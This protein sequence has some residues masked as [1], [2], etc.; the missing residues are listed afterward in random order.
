MIAITGKT[1]FKYAGMPQFKARLETLFMSG[2]QFI[3]F[4]MALV[5]S[6][7]NLLPPNHPYTQGQNIGKFGIRHVIAEAANNIILKKENTDQIVLFVVL[8]VGLVLI[9]MQ[10]ALLAMAIFMQP[11]FASMPT[12]FAGFFI[13][14]NPE[15]DIAHIMMDLIFGVGDNGNNLF[16]SCIA[17]EITCTETLP[18]PGS[19]TRAVMASTVPAVIGSPATTA[20]IFRGY[21]FPFPI[22]TGM[23][24]MFQ[25]YNTGLL[26]VGA[27][28]TSYFIF[29]IIAETAQTGTAFGKRFNKVWAPLRIVFAFGMLV[30]VGLGFNG[31]QYSVL[32]AA[33]FGSAFAT[34]GWLLFNSSIT[35]GYF[36]D[37][38]E[39]I[40][41]PNIPEITSLL[42]FFYVAKT[43]EKLEEVSAKAPLPGS[44][45]NRDLLIQMYL[46]KGAPNG[47]GQVYHL[48]NQ[49]TTYQQVVDFVENTSTVKIRFGTQNIDLYS[50][51][52]GT[53]NPLC[54][55]VIL[56]LQD[57]RN[58]SASGLLAPE[59]G[60]K[61]MQEFYWQLLKSA[62]FDVFT[63][64]HVISFEN[65]VDAIDILP[66]TNFPEN[67]VR[68][69][70]EWERDTNSPLPDANYARNVKNAFEEKIKEVILEGGVLEE[71]ANSDRFIVNNL[72]TEKGWAG[73]AIWYNR[74]AEMN[75]MVTTAILNVP[76]V[77]KYPDIMEHILSKKKLTDNNSSFETRFLPILNDGD[78]VQFPERRH[79]Q[80]ANALWFAFNH[81]QV[82]GV[83]SS[84][85]TPTG[86]AMIDSI[87][88]IFGT[89]GLYNIRRNP[90]THPLAQI[91]GVGRSL[92]ESSIRNLA[93]SVTGGA[94]GKLLGFIDDS[95]QQISG[96]G[97]TFLV[98]VSMVALTAGF[99]LFYIVPFLPFI[100]FFFAL[101]GWVK[102]I[103]EA[104]VGAPLWALAHIRIDQ[105][106]LPGQAGV[107][108][109]F[110]IFEIFI[111]P[112][113]IIFG[114]L[115]SISIF[116]AL[117][118][119]LH[120]IFDL[121]IE[122]VGGFDNRF[123]NQTSF[124]S[125]ENKVITN[126][127]PS[128]SISQAR[129]AIDE[130]FFTIIYTIIIYLMAMSSFKLIDLIPNNILRWMGQSIATFNDQR[131][132]AAQGLV[133]K[134][135]IGA[136]QTSSALGGGLKKFVG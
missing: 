110:L 37:A 96:I 78:P 64:E 129:G 97:A 62:W 108:G 27:M 24:Q 19:G 57:P 105:N 6:A 20:S 88:A 76:H 80:M 99:V 84:H 93:L 106:G 23:H 51:Y 102:G 28:I 85:A 74:I 134:A 70:T 44:I 122:N 87:N 136:Q 36:G 54:G 117:V 83:T 3:A 72:I 55:E 2:F 73:A 91:V 40:S 77:S 66:N 107:A 7:V 43:C 133:G 35:D 8:L 26:V 22:H 12:N 109:Y 63:S 112:I 31:S 103:F 125:L 123:A 120:Q 100:Y 49:G 59:E 113:L 92:V 131:E 75:G 81:W 39:L 42:Q 33:K 5:Y 128:V 79:A 15:T 21:G 58:P 34:N 135:T 114:M 132:D 38:K 65:S 118:G 1:I 90:N 13:T 48:V 14:A 25:L 56:K 126:F 121:V 10:I 71:M 9:F 98:T 53:V 50:Q 127:T 61:R 101:G 95:F 124:Q 104:M 67:I 119:V 4:F 30:P 18:A 29:T 46:V 32:Y 116:S 115:A 94:T 86:N 82:S 69:K 11:V 45:T 16:N 17:Q 68:N 60:V 52:I 111:R 41:T 89:E 130:F 47:V